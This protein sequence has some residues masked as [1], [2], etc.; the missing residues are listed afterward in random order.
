MRPCSA[1]TA[2]MC[3][4]GRGLAE[5]RVSPDGARVAFSST[6]LG[7][8]QLVVMPVPGGAESVATADPPPR[9]AA[10][11]GGG[12]FDWTPDGASLVYAAVDGGLWIVAADG[13][14]PREVVGARQVGGPASAPAVAPDGTRVAFAVDGHHI[15][16]YIANFSAPFQW[17]EER[18]LITESIRNHQ[19]RFQDIVDPETGAVAIQ[20]SVSG[21]DEEGRRE[22]AIHSRPQ[23]AGQEE[24]AE[25]PAWTCNAQ[26]TLSTEPTQPPEPL[27]A[28]PPEGARPLETDCE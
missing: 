3:A 18:N 15:A 17:L 24:L 26:G 1:I 19:F 4:Y 9:P 8:A 25:S 22:I 12:S 16:I 28:W 2:A 23:A 14:A 10:A 6:A 20:V 7:R 5:P 27:D 21:P 13:G 11:Y